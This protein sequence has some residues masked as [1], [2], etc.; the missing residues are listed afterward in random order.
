VLQDYLKGN[1]QFRDQVNSWQDGIRIATTPLVEKKIVTPNYVDAIIQNVE[2]NGNYII[3][4]PEVAM[5]HARP[6]Y[7]ALATGLS[8][9]QLK[10]PVLF[11]KQAPVT[12][13][14]ALAAQSNDGHLDLLAE[15][16]EALSEPEKVQAL[17]SADSEAAVLK[18]F[19]S[20]V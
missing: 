8:F 3:I 4:L 6:E 9:L 12:L 10:Q 5:P 1:I 2:Q 20:E 13:F 14:I 15:L 17:Q 18:V 11:P 7:G 19:E 16:G